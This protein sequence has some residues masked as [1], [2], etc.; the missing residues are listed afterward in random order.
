MLYNLRFSWYNLLM[1]RA[2]KLLQIIEEKDRKIAELERQLQ[3]LISQ[4]RLSK[5]NKFSASS[6]KTDE[7]QLRLFNEAEANAAPIV[8]EPK[9]TGVK[10]HYRRR[11]R[12]TTD[13]L[14]EGLPVEVIVH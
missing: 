7:A 10:A 14:P 5:H 11:T 6:E 13:K 2:E 9:L 8:P 3:W 1:D 12:L 4:I